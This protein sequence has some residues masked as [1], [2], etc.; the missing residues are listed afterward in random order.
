MDKSKLACEMTIERFTNGADSCYL[1]TFTLPRKVDI[2][3]ACK[4]WSDLGRDLVRTHDFRGV[5]AFEIHPGGHGLHVHVVTVSR[6]DV[7]AIRPCC[8]HHGWGRIHVEAIPSSRAK[9]IA[10]YCTKADRPKCLKGR[11]L[12][13]PMGKIQSTKVAHILCDT[14]LSRA[15]KCVSDAT[16]NKFFPMED[17]WKPKRNAFL[18]MQI[19]YRRLAGCAE[20]VCRLWDLTVDEF[21]LLAYL[22]GPCDVVLHVRAS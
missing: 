5:R 1:W 17:W 21:D 13:A 22:Y 2:P 14:P 18:R 16:L 7:S 12:W 3:T 11:R 15:M 9:Y 8:R 19:A 6:Y 10:K 20:T 4:M